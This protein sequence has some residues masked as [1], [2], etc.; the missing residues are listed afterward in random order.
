VTLTT[1]TEDAWNVSHV[2][3][4]LLYTCLPALST[5]AFSVEPPRGRSGLVQFH[6]HAARYDRPRIPT[7]LVVNGNL[8]SWALVKPPSRFTFW[9][10]IWMSIVILIRTA[11]LHSVGSGIYW[12][13]CTN[14]IAGISAVSRHAETVLGALRSH[15]K[16]G[17][18][19]RLP[20]TP[21]SL[22][23]RKYKLL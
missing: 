14:C 10:L 7:A 8:W 23:L 2:H 9:T 19:S 15:R 4:I 6:Q 13:W 22:H 20:L 12:I 11:E 17:I 16:W 5:P 1:V 18:L 21:C 3:L